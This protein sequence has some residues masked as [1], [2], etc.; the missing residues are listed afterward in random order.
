MQRTK[1]SF[2]KNAKERKN[3][4]IIAPYGNAISEFRPQFVRYTMSN[5]TTLSSRDCL[6]SAF[7]PSSSPPLC[8]SLIPSPPPPSRLVWGGAGRQGVVQENQLWHRV[9]SDFSSPAPRAYIGW[10]QAAVILV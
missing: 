9:A 5:N 6:T 4:F 7:P 10:L 8:K 3:C 2:I 1:R